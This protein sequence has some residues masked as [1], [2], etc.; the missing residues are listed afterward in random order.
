MIASRIWRALYDGARQRIDLEQRQVVSEP[1]HVR[2]RRAGRLQPLREALVADA[3]HHR[4]DQAAL[5]RPEVDGPSRAGG[6]GADA[7]QRIL[8]GTVVG[9]L[10]FARASAPRSRSRG[11]AR[12]CPARPPGMPEPE[13]AAACRPNRA[14]T[15]WS[16]TRRGR[17]RRA[18]S[19]Q[20][21]RAIH[22][23]VTL[24]AAGVSTVCG[25]YGAQSRSS[26]S[27]RLSGR[28][29]RNRTARRPSVW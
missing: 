20:G 23:A 26:T 13:P 9:N 15:A 14:S 28:V 25:K 1:A 2:R 7:A 21:T 4:G 16:H 18:E 19:E 5:R 12:A 8:A 29:A 10:A 24:G 27:A 11:T 3:G 17:G 6:L 22:R